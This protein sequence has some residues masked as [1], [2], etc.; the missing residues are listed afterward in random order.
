MCASQV[1]HGAEQFRELASIFW[2]EIGVPEGAEMQ[3]GHVGDVRVNGHHLAQNYRYL[4]RQGCGANNGA[5]AATCFILDRTQLEFLAALLFARAS[6]A[7]SSVC[8]RRSRLGR[9]GGMRIRMTSQN[10]FPS[11]RGHIDAEE[12]MIIPK[13]VWGDLRRTLQASFCCINTL[14]V[15]ALHPRHCQQ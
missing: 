9:R 14:K 10:S 2:K 5:F 4:V 15:E 7:P 11:L 12:Q 1:G 13:I 3:T 8:F 6:T